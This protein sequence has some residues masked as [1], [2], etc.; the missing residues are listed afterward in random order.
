MLMVL[1][2]PDLGT[3]L[4]YTPILIAGLFLGGINLRQGLIL[5]LTGAVLV[6]GVWSSG[7]LLKSYQKARLTSFIN[8]Q[9]DP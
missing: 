8:P 2:Q 3:T 9:N 1:R 5:I 7:K 4:T 6:G